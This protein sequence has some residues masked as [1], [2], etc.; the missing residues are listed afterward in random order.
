MVNLESSGDQVA[1]VTAQSKPQ[2]ALSGPP[3]HSHDNGQLLPA[4]PT[5]IEQLIPQVSNDNGK[6]HSDNNI[7]AVEAVNDPEVPASP[8]KSQQGDLD[9]LNFHR[10]TIL[11]PENSKDVETVSNSQGWRMP[12]VKIKVKRSTTSSKADETEKPASERSHGLRNESERGA[13]SSNSVDAPAINFNKSAGTRNQN[14]EESNSLHDHGSRMSASIGS[15][16]VISD[17]DDRVKELQCTADSSKLSL[18]SPKE[19]QTPA[20]I[21]ENSIPNPQAIRNDHGGAESLAELESH[22]HGGDHE[23]DKKKKKKRK[24]DDPEYLEKKR[25]KKEKKKQKAKEKEM[26]MQMPRNSAPQP[27]ASVDSHIMVNE[28]SEKPPVNAGQRNDAFEDKQSSKSIQQASTS[29]HG[30]QNEKIDPSEQDQNIVHPSVSVTPG[31]NQLAEGAAP[32]TTAT[33]VTNTVAAP[34]ESSAPPKFR[35]KIK[36]RKP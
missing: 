32:T 3:V 16:K 29:A 11:V 31:S 21:C 8:L 26:G 27:S 18:V 10:D 20:S 36:T 30:Q 13:T 7:P 28:S 17:I 19:D 22:L 34:K 9:S 33:N 15:V 2:D 1:D 14:F 25:L 6:A 4:T 24:R 23:N 5:D 12:V 35:I